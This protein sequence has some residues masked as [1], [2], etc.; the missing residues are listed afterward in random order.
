M[1]RMK[2]HL[3]HKIFILVKILKLK[4]L[5]VG[6]IMYFVFLVFFILKKE[7][8]KIYSFGDN[9]FGQTGFEIVE[10]EVIDSPKETNLSGIIFTKFYHNFI[11]IN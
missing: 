8:N 4:K 7:K 5:Y 3:F 10:D 2:I 11:Y 9:E 1:R 6:Q